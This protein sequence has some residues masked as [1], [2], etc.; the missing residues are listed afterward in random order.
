MYMCLLFVFENSLITKH[1]LRY[2]Y[3]FDN[4]QH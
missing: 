2:L 3:V 4:N 1:T